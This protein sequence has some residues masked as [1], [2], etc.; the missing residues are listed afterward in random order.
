VTS[1]PALAILLAAG[2]IGPPLAAQTLDTTTYADSATAALVAT[3]RIRHSAQDSLV[4]D[5]TAVVRTRIDASAGRSRFARAFP[6]IAHETVARVRWSRPND[7]KLDLLGVR[8][9]SPFSGVRPEVWLD[10][11]WFIPRAPDDSIRLM[12]VPETAALHPLAPGA[13]RYYHYAI[14]DSVTI[15]L[16]ER[17]VRAVDVRVVPKQLAP[18]LVAG[19]MWVDA[20]NGDLVRFMVTFLGQYL[21]SAPDSAA[22]AA[23]S[24]RVRHDNAR[25]RRYLSVQADLEYALVDGRYWM[26]SRQLLAVTLDVPWL[27]DASFPMRALTTFADYRINAAVPVAFRLPPDSGRR[28]RLV[29]NAPDDATYVRHADGCRRDYGFVHD[30][31]WSGGRWEIDAPPLDSLVAYHWAEPLRLQLDPAEA[32]HVQQTVAALAR[33]DENLPGQWT[34]RRVGEVRWVRLAD[35]IR[36]NRVQGPSLGVG[37]A[38]RPG[39]DFTTLQAT[40]RLGLSDRRP[41]GSLTWLRE[42]PAGRLEMGVFRRLDE[43]DPWSRGQSIGNSLNALFAGHDDANYFLASGA[44][45]AYMAYTGPLHDVTFRL[46]VV[47]ERSV[48]TVAGSRVSDW[49]GTSGALGPNPPIAEGDYLRAAVEPHRRL[50]YADVRVGIEAGLGDSLRAARGWLA[51]TVPF[52]IGGRRGALSVKTGVGVGDTMPQLMFA[53]GGPATVRGY[54]YGAEIGRGFWAAQLDLGVTRGWLATPVLFADVGSTFDQSDPLV[55]AG[56]GLSILDGWVRFDL[57]KGVHPAGAVRF[58]LRFGAPR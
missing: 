18:A 52:R 36:F 56:A 27:I 53:V 3:A 21:W 1:F 25:A 35:L 17:V 24:A 7:L 38:I 14:R 54:P 19:D 22:T 8:V 31:R 13:D 46:G 43:M 33:L 6:L 15:A 34:G 51:A 26:P 47:R 45:I 12:G 57:S 9:T 23:D 58:D 40:G 48:T 20:D 4:Q 28:R 39:P 30:G 10:R 5:Y 42:A 41:M 49:L 2:L 37:Y 32:R 29:C 16:P 11:P 44:N 50:P 55:G